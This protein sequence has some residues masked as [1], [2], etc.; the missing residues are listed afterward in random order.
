VVTP[1]HI[2]GTFDEALSEFRND[3]LTMA[4]LTER[5]LYSSL[6]LGIAVFVVEQGWA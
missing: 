4:E 2:L 3:L 1:K 6:Y 5:S